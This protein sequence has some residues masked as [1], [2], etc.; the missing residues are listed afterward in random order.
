MSSALA[1]A[2]AEMVW[3]RGC[4]KG[5]AGVGDVALFAAI[6]FHSVAMNG[7]VLHALTFRSATE[8][9]AAINGYRY[10]ELEGAANTLELGSQVL[11]FEG[12]SEELETLLNEQYGKC[13]P[14]DDVLHEKFLAALQERPGDFAPI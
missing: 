10:F 7:G 3:N 8:V 11:A 5:G 12:E 2:D 4:D 6:A 9:D 1:T 14:V 13:M